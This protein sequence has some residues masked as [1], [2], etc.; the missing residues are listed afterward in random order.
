MLSNLIIKNFGLIDNLELDLHSKLNIFTGETGA[1]KS[2]I[3]DALRIVLGDKMQS[4]LL[5]NKSKPC[6]IEAAFH[7]SNPEFL[8]KEC[9]QDLF[10]EDDNAQ[11]LIIQRI[12]QG[13]GRNKIKI[14]GLMATLSQ[15]KVIGQNLMDFHGPHDHQMLLSN[16]SHRELLD[17]L[18]DFGDIKL[19]YK[20]IYDQYLSITKQLK[21]LDNLSSNRENMMDLLSHQIKELE[22]IPLDEE[23]FE[24]IKQ[25]H[26]KICHAEKI[27]EHTNALLSSLNAADEHLRKSFFPMQKLSNIDSSTESIVNSLEQLQSVNN[28]CLLDL[29][30]Y[31]DEINFD[32]NY[33]NTIMQQ[34]DI[35][36]DIIRKY[37]KTASELQ[38]F[39]QDIKKQYDKLSNIEHDNKSLK[40]RLKELELELETINKKINKLRNKA[41]LHLKDTIE[42]E[43]VELGIQ[44]VKF[45]CK[46]EKQNL[47]AFGSDKVIFYI[48]PNLG[49]DLKPLS[50]I[51]SSGEAA[52]VML[53]FKKALI[54]VDPIPILV[55]DEIDA[56]IG[57]RLGTITGKKLKE[58]ANNRQVLLITHLPQIASFADKHFKVSKS[59]ANEKTITTVS[60]LNNDSQIDELTTMM[61]GEHKSQTARKYA[62][63]MLRQAE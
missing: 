20:N 9:F 39:Y 40:E 51:V 4:S 24:Y 58:I 6:I 11:E 27:K 25:E 53:A 16:D 48:S 19:K 28:Q 33:A 46:I 35:M 50:E 60:E 21:D 49:E 43:L 23:S 45:Y 38:N 1:G 63:D 57:G 34:Y 7:F 59:I 36:Q 56:Q 22:Q 42:K 14:N 17:R 18:I 5:R 32:S 54:K 61:S 12:F 30:A 10:F 3:I 2:I 13:S 47:T 44:N 55:F 62:L 15:L 31:S 8:N 37:G 52:R 29:K 41:A 26:I